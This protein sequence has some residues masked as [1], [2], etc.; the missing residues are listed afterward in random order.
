[1]VRQGFLATLVALLACAGP[2]RAA[3]IVTIAVP[4]DHVDPATAVFNGPQ[5]D[6]LRANVLLPDGYTPERRWPVLYLLHGI[7][8]THETWARDDRGR[9][10][11]LAGGL[12]AI[13]VMPEAG[14][15]F[16]TNWFNGGRRGDP[17]WERFYLDELIPLVEASFPVRR[18]RHH[19]AIAGLSMG[20]FGAAFL[21]GRRPDYFGSVA[22][23]SGFVQHQRPEVE[24]GLQ[25]LGGPEYERIFGPQDGPY[26][27][28]HNPT[29]L[30]ANLAHTRVFVAAGNGIAEPGVQGGATAQTAGGAVEAGLRVQNEEFVAALRDAGVD[31]TYRPQ[32]GVHDWPYWR[33]HL[34]QAI[35]WGL[36]GERADPPERWV[37]GTVAQTGR[38]WSLR[39]A[40]EDPPA[41][42]VTFERDGDRLRAAAEPAEGVGE[43]RIEDVL[44]GCG[45]DATVPFERALPRD[46]CGRIALRVKPRRI[47]GGRRTRLRVRALRIPRGGPRSPL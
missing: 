35:A 22:A 47:E 3:E 40:F 23:F 19:H 5:P 15:G 45:Y 31:V 10:A 18:G 27:T 4:S 25:A 28:G 6:A 7:G 20:G 26:A 11:E 41:G 34:G 36:F 39:F 37:H 30:A 21:G 8:D 44:T 33:R 42:V 1:M 24:A 29:R 9:I 12:G 14:R 17:G 13:V 2:A 46:P 38:M 32:G 43:V 16:Y